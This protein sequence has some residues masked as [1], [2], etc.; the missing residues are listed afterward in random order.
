[1]TFLTFLNQLLH[2]GRVTVAEDWQAPEEPELSEADRVLAEFER[3]YRLEMPGR[4]P[5]F[6]PPAGRWAGLQ[7]YRGCQFAVFRHVGAEAIA[8]CLAAPPPFPATAAA[9]YSV[10]IVFRFLPS[11]MQHAVSAAESDPLIEHLRSVCRQW[12]LSSVGVAKLG[13]GKVSEVFDHPSLL[14]LYA[15]RII[16]TKDLTRLEDCRVRA[17][18]ETALGMHGELAPEIAQALSGDPRSETSASSV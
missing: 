1:M 18:V 3:G 13:I 12:P 6:L 9:H 7:F 17:A 16:A 10:D 8:A 5:E 2:H 15:D 4:P 14:A 11:L